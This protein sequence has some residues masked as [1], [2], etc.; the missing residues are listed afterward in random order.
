MP[1]TFRVGDEVELKSGGPM[2]TVQDITPDDMVVCVWF[3]Q[4]ES[5]E[6]AFKSDTLKLTEHAYLI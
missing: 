3:D 5:K 4:N 6:R 2:M 1:T